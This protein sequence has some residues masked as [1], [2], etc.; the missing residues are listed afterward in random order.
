MTRESLYLSR[1]D[2]DQVNLPMSEIIRETAEN[3]S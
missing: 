2:S 3:R 1:R